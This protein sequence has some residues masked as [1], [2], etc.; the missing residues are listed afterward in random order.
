MGT[1]VGLDAVEA[2]CQIARNIL[3]DGHTI[4]EIQDV[5]GLTNAACS[6]G[7]GQTQ[8]KAVGD[9]GISSLFV[10]ADAIG[11]YEISLLTLATIVIVAA[12]EAVLDIAQIVSN[13]QIGHTL[14]E[15][16]DEAIITQDAAELQRCPNNVVLLQIA[17][18]LAVGEE[19]CDVG[20]PQSVLGA[21]I[22]TVTARN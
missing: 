2:S 11:I 13:G 16:I 7:T 6:V 1:H 3:V 12:P 8:H 4:T 22:E 10:C 9:D 19:L 18:L 17:V 15:N 14:P 20:V 21:Q 5:A